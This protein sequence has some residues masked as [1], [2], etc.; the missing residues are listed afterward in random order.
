MKH[1]TTKQCKCGK[2]YEMDF[3]D[4][5]FTCGECKPTIQKEMRTFIIRV[6]IGVA[7]LT[8]LSIIL[9]GI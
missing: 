1:T 2:D 8:I 4:E 9:G 3:V 7:L 6:L 5:K